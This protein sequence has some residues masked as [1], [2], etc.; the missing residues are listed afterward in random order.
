MKDFK[1]RGITEILS[2]SQQ[3]E[4]VIDQ[5]IT[6]LLS[7]PQGLEQWSIGRH[8]N[9]QSMPISISVSSNTS[10]PHVQAALASGYRNTISLPLTS[11]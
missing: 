1:Q 7:Q 3:P 6:L 4:E 9:G 11:Y 8:K 10:T 5:P 2:S